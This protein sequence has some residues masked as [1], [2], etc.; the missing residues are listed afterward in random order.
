MTN[1][2]K[3]IPNPTRGLLNEM[4]LISRWLFGTVSWNRMRD[5]V[6]CRSQEIKIS[7]TPH[8]YPGRFQSEWDVFMNDDGVEGSDRKRALYRSENPSGL[9][10]HESLPS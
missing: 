8:L 6:P 7:F 1:T 9:I 3:Q 2:N 4:T 10:V 5:G